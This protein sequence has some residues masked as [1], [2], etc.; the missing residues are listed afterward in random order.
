MPSD[1]VP[2]LLT[3]RFRPAT[4]TI[5]NSSRLELK[6]ARNFTRSRS[7][8]EAS[9]ASSKTRRLKSNQERS[10][11]INKRSSSCI[12]NRLK[13]HNLQILLPSW[14]YCKNLENTTQ[15]PCQL[16]LFILRAYWASF[17]SQTRPRIISSVPEV[18]RTRL[19]FD[20]YRVSA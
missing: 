17:Q 1:V 4:R 20:P 5:K 6:M 14:N 2:L 19:T 7:G 9:L 16:Y 15:S 10:R 13:K 12:N 8:T 18:R 11:S 3:R